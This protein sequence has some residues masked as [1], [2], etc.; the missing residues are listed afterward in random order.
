LLHNLVTNAIEALEGQSDGTITIATRRASSGGAEIAEI[1]VD[2][3]GPRFPSR[4]DRP[5]VRPRT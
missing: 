2:D 4:T 5:G 3:N 1:T